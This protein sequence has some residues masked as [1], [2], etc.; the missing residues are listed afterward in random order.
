MCSKVWNTAARPSG[1]RRLVV[2]CDMLDRSSF[3]HRTLV[4]IEETELKGG[5]SSYIVRN[6]QK[7]RFNQIS[8]GIG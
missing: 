3:I 2:Q 5:Y 7:Y 1:V 6:E 8:F 4:D